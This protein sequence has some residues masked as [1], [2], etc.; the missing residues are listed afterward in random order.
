MIIHFET[1]QFNHRNELID[2]DT[3]LVKNDKILF[4]FRDYLN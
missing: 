2:F 4:N 3:H 1:K